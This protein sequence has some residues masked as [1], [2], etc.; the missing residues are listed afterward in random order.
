MQFDTQYFLDLLFSTR[1]FDAIWAV[2][3]ITACSMAVGIAIGVLCGLILTSPVKWLHPPIKAYVAFYRGVPVL[4]QIVFWYNGLS[5]VTGG[6]ISLPA[7]VAGIIALGVN[8][9]AYMTEIIRSGIQSV[10][11]GQREASQALNLSYTSMMRKIILPQAFRIA[12]PPTG[13]EV[14]N[15]I[16]NTTLLFM[17]AVPEL[18][19]AAVNIYSQNFRYFEVLCV[20]AIW[21]I[22]IASTYTFIQGMIE[23]RLNQGRKTLFG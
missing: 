3:W 1:F 12:I 8:E 2:I 17:I 9:G 23:K 10:D 22:A 16:K 13:N 18:F 19:G 11:R 15:V 21:Y 6:A 7:V 5:A 20:I 14:I 4:V